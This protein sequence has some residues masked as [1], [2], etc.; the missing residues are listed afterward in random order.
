MENVHLVYDYDCKAKLL[1]R[2]QFTLWKILTKNIFNKIYSYF[3]FMKIISFLAMLLIVFN[4]SA[5]NLTEPI[6]SNGSDGCPKCYRGYISKNRSC[7]NCDGN[8]QINFT[9]TC[10][11][12]KGYPGM[13]RD[14]LELGFGECDGTCLRC[15]GEKKIK[16]YSEEIKERKCPTCKGSGECNRCN[17]Q[18]QVYGIKCSFCNGHK[19]CQ[20]CYS[21]GTLMEFTSSAISCP[22]CNG[23]GK[24]LKKYPS[25]DNKCH[26]KGEI[27]Y[28]IQKNPKITLADKNELAEYITLLKKETA[29]FALKMKLETEIKLLKAKQEDAKNL[30]LTANQFFNQNKYNEALNYYNLSLNAFHDTSIEIKKQRVSIILD[31]IKQLNTYIFNYLDFPKTGILDFRKNYKTQL[32]NY[33]V[34]PSTICKVIFTCNE[35]GNL[36]L[37]LDGIGS[38]Q[39]SDTIIAK[40]FDYPKPAA[41]YGYYVNAKSICNYQIETKTRATSVIIKGG[42]KKINDK[43][44]NFFQLKK[45]LPD[46]IDGRYFFDVG[47]ITIDGITKDIAP[48]FKSYKSFGGP[49]MAFLSLLVPGLGKSLITRSAKGLS[50]LTFT[51]GFAV[52][53]L[54]LKNKADRNYNNYMISKSQQEMDS[55]YEKYKNNMIGMKLSIGTAAAIWLLDIY[56]VYQQG[57]YNKIKVRK[58]KPSLSV[59]QNQKNIN[60]AILIK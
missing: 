14:I 52:A 13:C 5:Q 59:T 40:P 28:T 56:S 1:L 26:G 19:T 23:T 9:E 58:L 11:I 57:K 22:D 10:P 41:K 48:Q 38:K 35:K 8:G 46:S 29:E 54:V 34:G 33:Y 36:G 37:Q 47:T 51:S 15:A 45:A 16:E 42:E 24:C 3:H 39:L 53:G 32:L 2:N 49:G 18:G 21:T 44:V 6:L 17:G 30:S 60:I 43:S 20:K 7:D 4:I 12:C 31:S 50:T 55:Y 25:N 27:T